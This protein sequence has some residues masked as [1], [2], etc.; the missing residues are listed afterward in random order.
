M[1]DLPSN[2]EGINI[3]DIKDY[4]RDSFS[5]FLL[6]CIKALQDKVNKLEE[7]IKKEKTN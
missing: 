3:I 6:T 7:Q 2:K 4:N 1:E 5:K